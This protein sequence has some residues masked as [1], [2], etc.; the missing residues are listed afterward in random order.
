[1]DSKL[2]ALV[3]EKPVFGDDSSLE[4]LVNVR[5]PLRI[6]GPVADPKV[7]VNLSKIA[8][9]ALKETARQT[10]EEKLREKFG[11]GTPAEETAPADG[12]QAEPPAQ[13]EDPLKNALDRLFKKG[14]GL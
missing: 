7:G 2:T 8:K 9:E 10:L 14:T 12:E 11:L 13:P 4:D 5:I 6:S 3:F 1:L